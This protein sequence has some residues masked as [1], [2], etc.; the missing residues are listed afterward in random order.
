[1]TSISYLSMASSKT[2]PSV[3]LIIHDET[4]T[5]YQWVTSQ[6]GVGNPPI[7]WWWNRG[8]WNPS[9]ITVRHIERTIRPITNNE[10]STHL[11]WC[12]R[13]S[14]PAPPR[15]PWFRLAESRLGAGPAGGAL[16][17]FQLR[18]GARETMNNSFNMTHVGEWLHKEGERERERVNGVQ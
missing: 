16:W 7:T 3:M 4:V 5:I 17:L 10:P 2:S 11:L 9:V 15:K 6:V 1:M 8:L 14:H 13:Q 12:H 18:E